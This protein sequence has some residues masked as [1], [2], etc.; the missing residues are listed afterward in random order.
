MAGTC[1]LVGSGSCEWRKLVGVPLELLDA[2]VVIIRIILHIKNSELKEMAFTGFNRVK[3][4]FIVSSYILSG[5][6]LQGHQMQTFFG[7]R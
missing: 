1:A 5:K 4:A 6:M 2:T 3:N 7:H